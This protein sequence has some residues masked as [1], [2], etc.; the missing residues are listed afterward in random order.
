MTGDYTRDTFRRWRHYSAVREQQG[1]VHMDADWNEQIDIG[2]HLTR[3]TNVDVIGPTGMPEASPGF[4]ILPALTSPGADLLIGHGRAYVEGVQVEH[5]PGE[6]A[7]AKVSGSGVNTIW[8]VVS[9]PRLKSGQFVGIHPDPATSLSRVSAIE[10]AQQADQGRQRL[11]F[12]PALGSGQN[13]R[14]V[15]LASTL[16]QPFFP[17][18]TLPGTNGFY[19]AYLDVWEREI[20]HLEDEYLADVALGGPD[21]ALRTQVI[22]QV[23]LLPLAP[24]IAS[25]ALTSP[26]MCKS[27]PAG[28]VPNGQIRLQLRARAFQTQAATS[29][30]ELPAEGGYRSLENH[31]YR[32]EIHRGG[33]Q[34]TNPIFVKWSRDNA[35]HRTRVLDVADG[36]LVV[37][38]IGKDDVTALATDDWVELRDEGRILRG[39]PGFFVEIGEVV[40]MR[41]GIR[42]ILDPL[43][44]APLTQGGNPDTAVLPKQGLIH[45][46]EGGAPVELLPGQDLALEN[47]VIIASRTG[48]DFAAAGDYWLIPARSL[49]TSVEWPADPATGDPA[50]VPPHGVTHRYSP[51]AIVEKSTAGWLVKDDCRNIFPPLTRLESFFYLGGDGQ[52]AKPDPTANGPAAFAMLDS[53]LRVGVARGRTP[54]PG[55]PVRF[56]V[57]DQG[58]NSAKLSLAPG[59][60]AALIITNTPG[61]IVLRTDPGGVAQVCLA[62]HKSR[63]QNHLIAELLNASDPAQADIL[64]LPIIFTGRT[65]V[66]SEVAYDPANCIY[67]STPAIAPGTSK[68][69][70]AALDKLC[71]RLEFLPFGGDGQTLCAAKPG[72]WP[73]VVGAFWGKQSLDGLRVTFKVVAG[74]AEMVPDTATTNASGLATSRIVAGQDVLD[75]NGIVLVE[76]ELS[77]APTAGAP[78]KLIFAARFLNAECIYLGPDICPPGQ[79][80]TES[81]SLADIINYLCKKVQG[82][83]SEPGIRATGIYAKRSPRDKSWTT[84]LPAYGMIE[85]ELLRLGLYIELDRPVDPACVEGKPVGDLLI[86]LPFPVT[87]PDVNLWWMGGEN[88]RPF[89][90]DTIKLAGWFEPLIFEEGDKKNIA[91]GEKAPRRG[92]NTSTLKGL[93]WRPH[94]V[95]EEWLMTTNGVYEKL[96]GHPV[97]IPA[98]LLL[99]GS[100]VYTATSPRRYL[101]G[102]L[103]FDHTLPE[104]EK[105]KIGI[106]YPSGDGRAGGDL[107]LP[108]VIGKRD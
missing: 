18:F 83:D 43:T 6:T 77:N 72:P 53:A 36:S 44:L 104:K 41:L 63:H 65:S 20:T 78:P 3:T 23:K 25:G 5:L 31:L 8:E 51:L 102:E 103:F 28:W 71:P 2:H 50:A 87:G 94:K 96:F 62:V 32:V 76:A 55:R 26:P 73:L 80:A 59:T 67:Q 4:A 57:L 95:S 91:A 90:Y 7:L 98:E 70:Q 52:E 60:P 56:R 48:A 37:E 16:V 49:T 42:T 68:S 89:G 79:K 15:P 108:F 1:R 12:D 107:R 19:L 75:N 92:A 99:R 105:D 54:V 38:E 29:P 17:G 39:E 11:R 93:L 69:V 58:A 106:R 82:T 85:P 10:P 30:C 97:K 66:A 101:D 40:G 22:W 88:R 61:E 21:T 86:D 100:R 9:G 24:L 14:V 45:R 46:W 47:G 13:K 74:D 64:H 84:P 27:F 35:I 34:G 81:N 33:V